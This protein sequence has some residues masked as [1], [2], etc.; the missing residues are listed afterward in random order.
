ME[1]GARDGANEEESFGIEKCNSSVTVIAEGARSE[2]RHMEAK[3]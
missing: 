1:S 2:A 3:P